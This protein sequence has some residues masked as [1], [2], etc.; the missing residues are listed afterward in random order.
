MAGELALVTEAGVQGDL[1]QGQ[2]RPCLQEL[3][4]PLDATQDHVLV[5]RQPGG[6]LELPREV[7]GVE[8]DNLS[9]LRQGRAAVEV[10][11]IAA[12]TVLMGV[13][14]LLAH[15]AG[16]SSVS[17][18]LPSGRNIVAAWLSPVL[19][20]VQF[21]IDAL[22]ERRR[23]YEHHHGRVL[24]RHQVNDVPMLTHR[25]NAEQPVGEFGIGLMQVEADPTGHARDLR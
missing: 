10:L 9:Q 13:V 12:L 11:L 15:D 8:A 20:T 3:L 22:E 2:V 19:V 25:A 24:V 18:G 17:V 21:A 16:V 23:G 7:V 6:G 14:R 5:R 4:G 1:R